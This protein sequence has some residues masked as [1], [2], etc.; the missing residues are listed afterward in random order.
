MKTKNKQKTIFF[1]CERCER[2]VRVESMPIMDWVKD[3]L[4]CTN[5]MATYQQ[6]YVIENSH[7]GDPNE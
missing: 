5:C 7:L 6:S 4:C 1:I 3:I 2:T